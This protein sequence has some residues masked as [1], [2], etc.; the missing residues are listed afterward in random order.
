MDISII[1]AQE[2]NA[3]TGIHIGDPSAKTN[4]RIYEFALSLLSAMV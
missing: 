4:R 2:T 1:K 3:V